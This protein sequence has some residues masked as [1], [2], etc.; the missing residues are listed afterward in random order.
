MQQI[1]G[2][3]ITMQGG[4]VLMITTQSDEQPAGIWKTELKKARDV[5]DGNGGAAPILLPVLYEFPI[6]QQRDQSYWRD[7]RNW[8][9][10]L[11][12]LGRSIDPERLGADYDN[13]G[14]VNLEAE[15][16]WTSQH[17]NIEIGVGIGDDGW[18]GA[19]YWEQA[20][21][22]P[23][24]DLDELL[25]RSEVATIGG[26]SGGLDD[27]LAISVIGREKGTRH[28]LC[29]NHAWVDRDVLTLRKEIAP[30]LL[31]FETEGTLTICDMPQDMITGFGDIFRRVLASGLLPIKDGGR[32]RSEQRRSNHRETD[33]SLA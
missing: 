23:L 8:A 30:A 13:N 28:W 20:A 9:P 18:R 21:K 31:D 4:Q 1:R 29:W 12:N 10:I 6:E 15:K 5:R 11:P 32:G 14:K 7:K 17:L 19:T 25:R 24:A 16:I 33:V 22:T 27:L 3:G 26:D 2:G